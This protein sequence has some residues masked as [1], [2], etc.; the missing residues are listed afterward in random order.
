MGKYIGRVVRRKERQHGGVTSTFW[1]VIFFRGPSGELTD[2]RRDLLAIHLKPYERHNQVSFR[3]LA[4]Y[5]N[6]LAMCG[7]YIVYLFL[8]SLPQPGFR[9]VVAWAAHLL[10]S[11]LFLLTSLLPD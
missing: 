10:L 5:R 2:L 1:E 6:L 11:P 4:D 3:F 7:V 9:E 8:I